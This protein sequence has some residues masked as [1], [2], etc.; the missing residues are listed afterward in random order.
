[1]AHCRLAALR[2]SR[3]SR[4]YIPLHRCSP[5]LANRSSCARFERPSLSLRNA[6]NMARTY[7]SALR[8]LDSIQSN[9]AVTS[10]FSPTPT[11]SSTASS[12]PQD[13][14][15]L[16]IPEMLAWAQR[17]G[18]SPPDLAR[19][20]CIHVAGT[21]GKGSVCA[22]LTSILTHP[23]V[24]PAAG[25]VGTYTSPHLVSVRERIQIDGRPLSRAAFAQHF[26]CVWDALTAS[27]RAEAARSGSRVSEEEL[28]GPATKP[29]YFRLLTLVALRAFAACGVRSA[30]V[31]CGIGAEYDSTNILPREAVTCAVVAQLGVDHVG[32]LGAALPQIAWN[33]AGVM[34]QGRKCYTRNIGGQ[35][36]DGEATMRVL[37]DR[38]REKDAVLVE[39]EDREVEA[40]GGVKGDG[41][42][43]LEG[44]F[45][46]YNQALALRAASE[47]LRVLEGTSDMQQG[48]ESLVALAERFSEGLRLAR[49]RG[50]CETKEDGNFTWFI[51]G[52]H[53]ADSLA[54]AAKWF[55]AKRMALPSDTKV[56]LLFNQQERD[57]AKLLSSL[58]ESIRRVLGAST[59][60]GIFDYA[61]FTRNDVQRKAETEPERDLSVQEAAA[62][63]MQQL[64]PKTESVI[65]DNVAE[66]VEKIKGRLQGDETKVTVLAT[67]SLH[68]VGALLRTLEP[69]GE[70]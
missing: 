26:F 68:L 42:G 37:R 18:L 61:I 29:F 28:Q 59:D 47:H 7:E 14:N 12:S 5:G 10:L 65:V 36:T 25:R 16:A 58:L 31:E 40:W 63:A 8:H 60:T 46:K 21:K 49:L 20:N 67:G 11:P 30:V 44:E 35:G 53:T 51:D 15:A 1:M 43:C 24:A 27:A 57:V 41:V 23:G 6:S 55:A 48:E 39:V 3:A 34:K 66:A 54:E 4:L 2:S 45:Q 70:V 69:E 52:A 38:A 50:R 19:L 56:V 13:L 62:D 64:C 33:K 22:Y 17:A 9:R 32:M